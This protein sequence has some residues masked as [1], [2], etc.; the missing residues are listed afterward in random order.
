[1]NLYNAKGYIIVLAFSITNVLFFKYYPLK[2]FT[3]VYALN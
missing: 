3:C 2:Y 1:M